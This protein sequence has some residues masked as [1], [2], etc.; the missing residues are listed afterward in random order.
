[1]FETITRTTGNKA[2]DKKIDVIAPVPVMT[3]RVITRV[4]SV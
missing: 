3:L 1:M 2:R 4:A